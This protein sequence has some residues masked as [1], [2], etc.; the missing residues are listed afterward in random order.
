MLKVK[1]QVVQGHLALC[2]DNSEENI[3]NLQYAA[4]GSIKIAVFGDNCEVEIYSWFPACGQ[5]GAYVAYR[6]CG[7]ACKGQTPYFALSCYTLTCLIKES[8]VSYKGDLFFW[9]QTG[10]SFFDRILL[11]RFYS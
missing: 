10:R 2:V 4:L 7:R 9:R 3:Y 11:T 1:R 5:G 8:V 6:V